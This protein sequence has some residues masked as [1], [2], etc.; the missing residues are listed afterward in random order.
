MTV[1]TSSSRLSGTELVEKGECEDEEIPEFV[2][3]LFLTSKTQEIFGCKA[4][5]DVT[6]DSTFKLIPKEDILQDYKNRA[7]ISDFHPAKSIVQVK[8]QATHV[9]DILSTEKRKRPLFILT[10]LGIF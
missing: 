2:F 7:A 10:G 4:D 8:I 3:P 6:A 5:E 1:P 9:K